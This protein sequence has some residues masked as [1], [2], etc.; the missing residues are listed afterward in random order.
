ML[1]GFKITYKPPF[2]NNSQKLTASMQRIADSLNEMYA[3]E[4]TPDFSVPGESTV[5]AAGSEFADTTMSEDEFLETET[6][7]EFEPDEQ[8]ITY[9]EDQVRVVNGVV[10]SRNPDGSLGEVLSIEEGADTQKVLDQLVTPTRYGETVSGVSYD[11][12]SKAVSFLYDEQVLI[13]YYKRTE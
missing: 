10:Y 3:P 1:D 6:F 4:P 5:D 8:F 7:Q 12:D 2:L 9:P 11:L 13:N